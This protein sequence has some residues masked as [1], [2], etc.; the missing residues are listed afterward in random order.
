MPHIIVKLWP[1]K[2]DAQKSRLSESITRSVTDI[3]GY[4]EDAVSVAIQEVAP[5]DWTEQVYHPD[6]VGRW[7]DL[8]KRPGY[9]SGILSI[10][11]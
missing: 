3:L 2:S 10:H 8:V 1:G 4:G 9:S 5:E 11:R 6:I 7:D